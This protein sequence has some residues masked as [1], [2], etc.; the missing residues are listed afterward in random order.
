MAFARAHSAY[1][2][3]LYKDLPETVQEPSLLP[4]TDRKKLMARFDD[5]VTD[6]EV[7]IE[8]T[9][10]FIDKPDL[11]GEKFLG[12]YSA[13]TTSGTS[14]T[15]GIFVWDDRAMTVTYAL[16]LGRMIRDWLR[17]GDIFRIVSLGGRMTMVCATGGHYAEAVAGARLRK[18]R[19]DKAVQV[20]SAHAPIAE[21][22]SKLN[23]FRPSILAPYASAAALLAGEQL[24]GR[25]RINPALVVLSA[26]GL[27][28]SGY[29]RIAEAF[30]VK[31]HHSYAATECPFLSYSC[32]HN[33]LHFNSDWVILEPVDADYRPTAPGK[34]S[35]TVLISN[36]ANRVQPILRYD[37]GDRIVQRPDSCP[38]GNPLPAIR[39]EGR[40]ADLLTFPTERGERESIPALMFEVVDAFGVELYQIVQSAP[41][42]LRVRLRPAAGADPERVWQ[43]V[44]GEIRRLLTD[45]GLAQVSVERA[46]EPPEQSP[47]GKYRA[48]IPLS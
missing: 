5:W 17:I 44:E 37:L 43:A 35:H 8:K 30:K 2:R 10:A 11:I 34:Q 39:V 26:E 18:Q 41:T 48:V 46:Q 7:T 3:E 15:P 28:E 36:L 16:A 45:R 31:V 22:V 25:L 42:T 20:L 21:M 47:G 6:R 32:K 4:V 38:C 1:Y 40:T 12:K 27:P 9:R 23:S 29:A 14:G 24:A 13:L 33:W 19:G